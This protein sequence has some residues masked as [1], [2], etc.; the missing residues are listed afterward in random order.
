MKNTLIAAALFA[1]AF[2]CAAQENTP[3]PS[4][5]HKE[6]TLTTIERKIYRALIEEEWDYFASGKKSSLGYNNTLTRKTVDQLVFDFHENEFKAIRQ[7][8]GK[9]ILVSGKVESIE[10]G[11]GDSPIVSFKHSQKGNYRD[12][13]AHFQR[14]QWGRVEELKRGQSLTLLCNEPQEIIGNV[15][16]NN[17]TFTES[18]MLRVPFIADAWH[19][20]EGGY[21]TRL[22]IVVKGVSLQT[23]E[24]S[25]CNGEYDIKCFA[26]EADKLRKIAPI[27]A[28]K[29]LEENGYI[30]PSEVELQNQLEKSGFE[31]EDKRK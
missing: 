10:A 31:I 18:S 13:Q 4:K 5:A 15:V 20:K 9:Y 3:A 16:L 12:A 24:F 29:K 6:L 19:F 1:T 25:N 27:K 17:C 23:N 30:I 11:I 22:S 2:S 8:K 21:S 7:L 28:R 26:S 14:D